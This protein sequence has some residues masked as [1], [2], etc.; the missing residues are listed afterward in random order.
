MGLILRAFLTQGG[1]LTLERGDLAAQLG[2][3]LVFAAH[4]GLEGLHLF[5]SGGEVGAQAVVFGDELLHVATGA[6]FLELF[7]IGGE[8]EGFG[9]GGIAFLGGDIGFFHRL[10]ACFDGVIALFEQLG[11]F[12][13]DFGL[14]GFDGSH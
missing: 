10:V 2:D 9:G 1:E 11:A 7:Q 3:F 13:V 6:L 5:F 14:F 4:I 12:G 8:A